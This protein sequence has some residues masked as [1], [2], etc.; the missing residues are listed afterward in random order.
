MRDKP[1]SIPI[2]EEILDV[3]ANA[4]K[5]NSNYEPGH[6]H[7]KVREQIFRALGPDT[8]DEPEHRRD[9]VERACA[10][11]AEGIRARV[12]QIY[13]P[14]GVKNPLWVDKN[15][16]D[17]LEVFR[18]SPRTLLKTAQEVLT[19]PADQI[20]GSRDRK[21]SFA[22]TFVLPPYIIIDPARLSDRFVAQLGFGHLLAPRGSSAL[23]RLQAKIA[24]IPHI[25]ETLKHLAP[26]ALA[27]TAN[28]EPFTRSKK[29]GRLFVITEGPKKGFILC[30][31]RIAG[32]ERFALMDLYK[33]RR[34]VSHVEKQYAAERAQLID[35][36][37]QLRNIGIQISDHW[38]EAKS[39]EQ[40]TGILG[41]LE[42]TAVSL[43]MVLDKDKIKLLRMIENIS[44]MISAKNP[45][46]ALAC[47][48]RALI[49]IDIRLGSVPEIMGE[50]SKDRIIADGHVAREERA[51]K[52]LYGIVQHEGGHPRLADPEAPLQETEILQ[53]RA[54]VHRLVEDCAQ[55]EFLQPNAPFAAKLVQ[56]LAHTRRLLQ[57]RRPNRRELAAIFMRAYV[58][59]KLADFHGF[60]LQLYED[61]SINGDDKTKA[62]VN[63]AGWKSKLAQAAA[64][65]SV[66]DVSRGVYTPE[67]NPIWAGVRALT[68]TL[69]T[70][71]DEYANGNAEQK[72]LAIKKLKKAV[73][74]F[75]MPGKVA[76]VG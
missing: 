11:I 58:V 75:D 41:E 26:M 9:K 20:A 73:A 56:Y 76:A 33:A 45:R 66:R 15:R 14:N 55:I 43:Q 17:A 22:Q 38:D 70:Y 36:D 49:V 74:D 39:P 6:L 50:L 30:A 59:S 47:V 53:I 32:S 27:P 44:R 52:R 48:A 5:F 71:M 13:L 24:T 8:I 69:E 34:R 23:E 18:A 68:A 12:A 72:A 10:L 21:T 29:S 63:V 31:Q 2:P 37:E 35:I 46:P 64:E 65:F 40:L 25:K 62:G 1:A 54:R 28:D 51:L 60:L 4:A 42:K 19:H 3:L 57:S 61:F 67:Y 16:G 7:P